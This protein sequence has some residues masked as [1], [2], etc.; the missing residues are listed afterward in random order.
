MKTNA[1]VGDAV[2]GT[3]QDGV[4]IWFCWR[5]SFGCCGMLATLAYE[6]EYGQDLVTVV[7]TDD[8]RAQI[9]IPA[10]GSELTL[11]ARPVL[12]LAPWLQY[13]EKQHFFGV[14]TRPL[15]RSSRGRQYQEQ[16]RNALRS[17]AEMR[18]DGEF[19]SDPFHHD[20]PGIMEEIAEDYNK[21]KV[22][23]IKDVLVA[24]H[25]EKRQRDPLK[26]YH[27]LPAIVECRSCRARSRIPAVR[28]VK[29]VVKGRLVK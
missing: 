26:A 13:R 7:H 5:I 25:D 3:D 27:V 18:T 21:D 9:A 28:G 19:L 22:R 23:A 24:R 11:N 17:A 29:D 6:D 20:A 16:S 10:S 8:S 12:F 14:Q 1:I 2:F 15:T 4:E